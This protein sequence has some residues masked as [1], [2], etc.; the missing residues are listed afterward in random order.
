MPQVL[1]WPM[2]EVMLEVD[3]V[4]FGQAVHELAAKGWKLIN[5]HRVS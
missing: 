1:L 4:T 2:A 3:D 5:Y